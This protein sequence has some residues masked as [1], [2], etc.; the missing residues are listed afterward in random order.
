MWER[1][2]E[3]SLAL[4]LLAG[5]FEGTETGTDTVLARKELWVLL[6]PRRRLEELRLLWY[7]RTVWLGAGSTKAGETWR[8]DGNWGGGSSY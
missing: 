4:A 2:K 6:G 3:R 7:W 5:A 8:K 1:G